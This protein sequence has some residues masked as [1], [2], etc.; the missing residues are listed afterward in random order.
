H[1]QRGDVVGMDEQYA[2][3]AEYATV[4]VVEAVD[5]GVVLVVRAGGG[6]REHR[7]GAV[8]A[9]GAVD[10]VV[11]GDFRGDAVRPAAGRV[12][13]AVA[14]GVGQAEAAGHAHARVEV[15]EVV[16]GLR[17]QVADAVVVADQPQPRHLAAHAERGAGQVGDDR[18]FGQQLVGGGR[19]DARRQVHHA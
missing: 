2:A 1:P 17:D 15:V 12:P 9:A 10:G 3:F 16:E 7:P 13:D 8:R 11:G 18:G 19:I 4:A 5:G 14:R 6:E